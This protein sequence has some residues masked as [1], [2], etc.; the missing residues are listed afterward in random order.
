MLK[1]SENLAGVT[2]L[3]FGN[4]SPDIF[5]SL[6]NSSGDTVLMYSELIGAACFVTGFIAGVVILIRPF[7]VSARNYVRDVLFFLCAAIIISSCMHDQGYSLV[8]GF[9]TVSIYAAYL[10]YVVV[11]HIRMK[12][13]LEKIRRL[14][15][16]SIAAG[17]EPKLEMIK[18]VEELEEATEIQIRRRDSSVVLEE[19]SKPLESETPVAANESLFKTFLQSLNPIDCRDWVDA[20]WI[21][22]VLMVLKVRSEVS[23]P[24]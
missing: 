17:E 11:D 4:G 5:A 22:R 6:S 21:R 7:K 24:N 2:L 12:R 1:M 9:A 14:S 23:H 10:A 15:L 18:E 13:K 3:A 16:T 8:E 20:G 19:V